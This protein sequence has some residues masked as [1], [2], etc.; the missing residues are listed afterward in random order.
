MTLAIVLRFPFWYYDVAAGVCRGELSRIGIALDSALLERFDRSIAQLGYTN[1]SE[2]FRD[3]IRNRLV[4]ERTTQMMRRRAVPGASVCRKR[5][6][7]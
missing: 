7:S 2:A 5:L 4:S 6:G 1:R 3:L